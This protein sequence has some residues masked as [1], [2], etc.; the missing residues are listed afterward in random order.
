[1]V[2][3]HIIAQV[4][5]ISMQLLNFYTYYFQHLAVD[6]LPDISGRLISMPLLVIG[7]L[8]YGNCFHKL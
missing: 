4:V 3:L 8:L 2:I 5:I 7:T 1:M 6:P